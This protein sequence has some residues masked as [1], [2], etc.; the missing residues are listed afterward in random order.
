MKISLVD[1]I[2]F[3]DLGVINLRFIK[4]TVVDQ[5]AYDEFHRS[6]IEPGA[7]PLVQMA[8]VNADLVR[9]G[10]E[11]IDDDKVL[12]IAS[13]AERVQTKDVI[14]KFVAARS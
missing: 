9:M 7:D 6:V 2:G 4:R 8:A 10:Y 5:K 11:A 3:T 14:A 13:L 1:Q 12:M